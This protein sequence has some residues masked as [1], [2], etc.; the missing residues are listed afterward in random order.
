MTSELDRIK[1]RGFL[2]VWNSREISSGTKFQYSNSQL[3]S[4]TSI[5][6]VKLRL[7][8]VGYNYQNVFV[9]ALVIATVLGLGSSFVGGQLGFIL[10]YASALFPVT[11]VGIGS[12]A[13][14]LLGDIINKSKWVIFMLIALVFGFSLNAINSQWTFRYFIDP[15]AKKKYV[16]VNAGKFL[17]GY[18]LGLPVSRFSTGGFSNE[19][20]F[21]QIRPSSNA[22]EDKQMFARNKYKQIDIARS[23]VV[24]LAGSVDFLL[25][26][27]WFEDIFIS[28]SL[29]SGMHRI[30]R[31]E[32]NECE[33]RQYVVRI[34]EGCGS[35]LVTWECAGPC[36]VYTNP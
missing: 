2:N 23:S 19:V 6:P 35:C 18:V 26:S 15:E 13:P 1:G 36:E 12:I 25:L 28:V 3:T 10:G 33:W 30:R 27:R 5:E 22:I 32:W 8:D 21:F 16:K 4:K 34:N 14:A 7:D 24:C 17:A 11:L 9:A 29:G 31:S 20:E